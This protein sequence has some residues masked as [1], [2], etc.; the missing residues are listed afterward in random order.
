MSGMKVVTKSFYTIVNPRKLKQLETK[1]LAAGRKG[2]I[3]LFNKLQIGPVDLADHFAVYK[4]RLDSYLLVTIDSNGLQKKPVMQETKGLTANCEY[5]VQQPLIENRFLK[6]SKP[7]K[8]NTR[9]L[10]HDTFAY[11]IKIAKEENKKTR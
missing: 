4:F 2:E 1:G 5:T 3:F 11:G 9:K 10:M 6:I 7:L 8:P